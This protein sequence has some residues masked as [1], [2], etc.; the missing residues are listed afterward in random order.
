MA[1]SI[2]E[3]KQAVKEMLVEKRFGSSS[4]TIVIEQFLDG[5]EFSVLAFS[6][7]KNIRL[8]PTAQDHKRNYPLSLYFLLR[9]LIKFFGFSRCL[10]QRSGT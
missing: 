2:A 7:G 1:K 10:L 9:K 4:E 5:D 3:A 6:D 8:M